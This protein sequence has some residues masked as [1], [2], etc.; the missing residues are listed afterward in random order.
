[1]SQSSIL[2][3]TLD[4]SR[5]L[6]K[7]YLSFLKEVDM[8]QPIKIN[9]E[10]FN[11]PLWI[12]AH[13]AWAENFLVLQSTGG[14]ALQIDWLEHF[15]LGATNSNSFL[16]E[17]KEVLNT[18]KSIHEASLQH[19]LTLTDEQLSEPTLTGISFGEDTKKRVIQ[20]V[21][22]HESTHAGHLSWI[23]KYYG[24]KTI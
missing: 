9:N 22:R 6:V 5:G 23:C 7:W 17:T 16:P 10:E 2:A 24:I 4:L 18:M 20:H 14:K 8:K 21:I 11:S 15:K 19:I 1:M 13:L 3:E 12:A